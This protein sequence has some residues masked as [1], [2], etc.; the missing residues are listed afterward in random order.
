M[1]LL[2]GQTH[3]SFYLARVYY[4]T[5]DIKYILKLFYCVQSLGA[6]TPCPFICH[7]KE[8]VYTPFVNLPL[9]NVNPFDTYLVLNFASF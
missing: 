5:D 2:I 3:H 8:K 1:L 9:T 4:A 7:L 6:P